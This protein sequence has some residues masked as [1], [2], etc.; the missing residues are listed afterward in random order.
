MRIE[1]TVWKFEVNKIIFQ[2]SRVLEVLKYKENDLLGWKI[3]VNSATRQ[4][5]TGT[6]LCIKSIWRLS[7][8]MHLQ[9]K[10][11]SIFLLFNRTS[12]H[13]WSDYH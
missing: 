3:D 7:P 1:N 8:A 2:I 9:I 10:K 4:P 11:K 6:T 5:I 13:F 12:N